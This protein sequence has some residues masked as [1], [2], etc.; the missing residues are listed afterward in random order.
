MSCI[1]TPNRLRRSLLL[2][3]T[4][5]TFFPTSEW[6]PLT[7]L[8][9][10]DFL[11]NLMSAIG[12]GEVKPGVQIARTRTD[13]P[14]PGQAIA[15]GNFVDTVGLHHFREVPDLAHGA[16]VRFGFVGRLRRGARGQ[17]TVE[18][19][20]DV[21]A[22]LCGEVLGTKTVE[23]QPFAIGPDEDDAVI[24]P[25]TD[26]SPTVGVDRLKAVFVLLDNHNDALAYRLVV[27]G[28]LDR[29]AP[30]P[31]VSVEG[32]AW[33]H[34]AVGSSERNTGEQAVPVA[35]RFADRSLFQLGL[36]YRR[37]QGSQRNPRCIIHALAHC[38]Y[39]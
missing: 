5:E 13:K 36:A 33:T 15:A 9:A 2:T 1:R 22:K 3:S 18:V 26:W 21:A 30:D 29:M 4:T 8:T 20:M 25:I 7:G 27:R 38:R 12:P 10:V 19:E 37:K 11:L 24:V 14:D 32:K 31:W 6:M 34:A 28:A 23:V 35:A 16:F 17:S 39:A